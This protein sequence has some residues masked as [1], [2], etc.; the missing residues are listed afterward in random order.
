MAV[1]VLHFSVQCLAVEAARGASFLGCAV[2]QYGDMCVD[3]KSRFLNRQYI[4]Q[5]DIV[6]LRKCHFAGRLPETGVSLSGDG[7]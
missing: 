4:L 2:F 3:D 7:S 5:L 6:M 1:L